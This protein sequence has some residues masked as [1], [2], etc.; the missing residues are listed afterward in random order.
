[1]EHDQC[2]ALLH[3]LQGTRICR[4]SIPKL[5][6]QGL[7]S[8]LQQQHTSRAASYTSCRGLLVVAG[9]ACLSNTPGA[10][11]CPSRISVPPMRSLQ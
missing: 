8:I 7:R 2:T 5:S 1:M 10:V 4:C 3:C 6:G 9:T 11:H